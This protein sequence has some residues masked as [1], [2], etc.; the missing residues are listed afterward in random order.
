[1]IS[2]L[3]HQQKEILESIDKKDF[4]EKA[5][6]TFRAMKDTIDEVKSTKDEFQKKQSRFEEWKKE[7]DIIDTEFREI[8]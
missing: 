3:Q 7:G 5:F 4:I 6:P 1:M 8:R 2:D